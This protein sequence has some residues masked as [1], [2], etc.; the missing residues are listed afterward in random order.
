[1]TTKFRNIA[2]DFDN[3]LTEFPDLLAVFVRMAQEKGH[4]VCCVT[5]RRE[6]EENVIDLDNWLFENQ[7]SMPVFFTSLQSKMTY[8]AN[9]GI[10]INLWIDDDPKTLVNGH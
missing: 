6:T 10:N 3:T 2:I 7:L 9:R 4:W 5:A 8:M 1:M